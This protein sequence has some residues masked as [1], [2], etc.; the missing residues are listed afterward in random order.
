V[1]EPLTRLYGAVRQHAPLVV[2]LL[3]AVAYLVLMGA[4]SLRRHQNLG[5]NALDLGYTDQ[6]VWNT[7]HGRPFRFST[8]LDAAFT[9]DIPIQQFKRPDLLLGY[10]VEPIL[11]VIAPLYLLYD[12]PETL[13]WLQTVGI[14]LGAIPVYLIARRRVA[15]R[16]MPG[17][18]NQE[19]ASAPSWRGVVPWL[20]VAFVMIYLLSPPLQAANLSDFHAVALSPVLLLAAFYSLETDRPWGFVGFAFLAALCKEEIG[21]LVAMLGLWAALARRHR[22][23]GL[24]VALAGTGW[25][26]LCFAFIM[27][28]YNG[29]PGSAFLVRYNQFG[30]NLPAILGNLVYRPD[31]FVTW[32][33]RLDVL[34]YLRD[35][36]LSSGGLSVLHPLAAAMALP[37]IAINVFSNSDW[38]RSGGAHYSASTV[39]F[40]VI[41]AIYGVDWAACTIGK[42]RG[43]LGRL[44]HGAGNA[45]GSDR[46]V[47][48]PLYGLISVAL[49]GLGLVV[50]LTNHHER[51]V[52][53]LSRRFLLEAVSEHA[54][55]ARPFIERVNDLPPEVPISVGSNLYPHVAHR[56]RVYLFPTVSDAQYIILDI[57]GPPYP[58]GTGDQVQILRDL[59]EHGLFG[60]AAADHGLL[61]LQEGLVSYHWPPQFYDV[62]Q[63]RN[64]TPCFRLGTDFGSLLRLEGFDWVVRPVVSASP[65]VEITTYWRPLSPLEGQYRLI[66]FFLDERGRVERAEPE[67]IAT[68]W[69]PPRMWEPG[70]VV[71]VA[72]QPSPLGSASRLGVA[73]VGPGATESDVAGR[74]A[75]ITSSTGQALTLWEQGTIL[76]LRRP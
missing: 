33:R 50:A 49:V 7:L 29:L 23:L 32:L 17:A 63:A 44:A 15:L 54:L 66:Y 20:P 11:A 16:H 9:L 58:I 2:T 60:V 62:F 40:L 57:T 13:L 43:W 55:R 75:P 47:P 42:V 72:R 65:I 3:L 26:L 68:N 56:Q 64:T 76:E 61:L 37:E 5:T 35:L 4:L 36:W 18:K 14:A 31:L 22:V 1:A 74:V 34:H 12:G 70:K 67:E 27:P 52:L 24:G 25:S 6:A 53:P 8:Y 30:E 45:W 48:Q 73:V 21:L 46:A 71:K 69:Y 51:G 19:S 41:S 59:M 28:H 38:M 10:H 39:P